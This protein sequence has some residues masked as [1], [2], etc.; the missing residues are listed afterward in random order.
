MSY[1]SDY[2]VEMPQEAYDD[3]LEAA[4]REKEANRDNLLTFIATGLTAGTVKEDGTHILVWK[5]KDYRKNKMWSWLNYQMQFSDSEGIAIVRSGEADE[6][7]TGTPTYLEIVKEL[8][9]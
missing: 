4:N 1:Y 7:I 8:R 3:L 5:N 2:A 6:E 9:W